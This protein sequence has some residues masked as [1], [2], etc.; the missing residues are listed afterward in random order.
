MNRLFGIPDGQLE[1]MVDLPHGHEM[2]SPA[3]R[4]PA[5]F[6]SN[7]W[8]NPIS[9]QNSIALCPNTVISRLVSLLIGRGVAT[10]LWVPVGSC[11]V[12]LL[13]T[14]GRSSQSR[15]DGASFGAVKNSVSY[16]S[17]ALDCRSVMSRKAFIAFH[18]L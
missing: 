11:L 17:V 5:G 10:L 9:F 18:L 12:Y 16:C 15:R 8:E 4:L 2:P 3:L 7:T 13:G 14:A 6:F 1:N